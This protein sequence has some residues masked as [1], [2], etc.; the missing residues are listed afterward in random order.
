[1]VP[2]IA[3]LLLGDERTLTTDPVTI[4]DAASASAGSKTTSITANVKTNMKILFM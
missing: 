4:P 3:A 2:I 1:M